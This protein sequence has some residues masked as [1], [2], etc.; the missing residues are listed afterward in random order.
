MCYVL[1]ILRNVPAV[2]YTWSK[3]C[4]ENF[5]MGGGICVH[6]KEKRHVRDH[7]DDLLKAKRPFR[8]QGNLGN[9]MKV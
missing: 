9:E 5:P 8:W 6:Q 1:S 4:N 7:G 2:V 3:V